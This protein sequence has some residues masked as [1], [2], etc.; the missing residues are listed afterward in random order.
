MGLALDG[1]RENEQT[2]KIDGVEILVND[3]ALPYVPGNVIDYARSPQGDGF[4]IY[5]ESGRCC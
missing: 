2:V 3:D 5:S 4:T 1:P